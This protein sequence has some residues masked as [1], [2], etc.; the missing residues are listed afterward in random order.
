MRWFSHNSPLPDL[1]QQQ[2]ALLLKLFNETE[3]PL[4]WG[5][6]IRLFLYHR[7]PCAPLLNREKH[8]IPKVY[9][10]WYISPSHAQQANLE[11]Y[12]CCNIRRFVVA[13]TRLC[14]LKILLSFHGL[15]KRR[16]CKWGQQ[17][18]HHTTQTPGAS[19]LPT[20]VQDLIRSIKLPGRQRQQVQDSTPTQ[21]CI[22]NKAIGVYTCPRGRHRT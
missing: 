8:G 16:C 22:P 15:H 21:H 17:R 4:G 10:H 20:H 19:W 18:G 9:A 12:R 6:K 5:H 3:Q 7:P 14:P 11:S 13:C 1:Q 2:C